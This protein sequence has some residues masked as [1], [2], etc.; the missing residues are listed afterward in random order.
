[1]WA[2]QVKA[3][4][5]YQPN[6]GGKHIFLYFLA[7]GITISEFINQ[8]LIDTSFVIGITSSLFWSGASRFQS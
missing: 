2:P 3:A 5:D 7:S 8:S 1:M 4:G 6:M